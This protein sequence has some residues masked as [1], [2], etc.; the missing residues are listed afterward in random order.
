LAP[1]PCIFGSGFD[2][3]GQHHI[4]NVSELLQNAVVVLDVRVIRVVLGGGR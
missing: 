2:V 3:F 1:L 4:D